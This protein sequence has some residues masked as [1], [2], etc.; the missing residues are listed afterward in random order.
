[1]AHR[2]ILL[3]VLMVLILYFHL[4]PLLVV[5]VVEAEVIPTEAVEVLAGALKL[6]QPL[7]TE[8]QTKEATVVL[9]LAAR[10]SHP[11]VVEAVLEP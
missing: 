1:M 7:E 10:A 5:V 2:L 11:A 6:R 3:K 4:S 8:L 9:V